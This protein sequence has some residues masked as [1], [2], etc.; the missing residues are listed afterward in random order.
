[1]KLNIEQRKI[2]ELEPSGHILVKGVA[3]SGK[4]TVAVHRASFLH[5]NYCPEPADQL[6]IVTFIKRLLKY[7][8]NQYERVKEGNKKI[9]IFD[10]FESNRKF[11]LKNFNRLMFR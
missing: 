1:M 9:P 11:V 5:R 8:R 7:I 3:G 2:I 6:L 4:T 10:W